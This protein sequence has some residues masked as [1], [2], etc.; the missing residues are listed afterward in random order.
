MSIFKNVCF[1]QWGRGHNHYNKAVKT[2][3][4]ESAGPM[5]DG[6]VTEAYNTYLKGIKQKAEEPVRMNTFVKRTWAEINLDHIAHNYR[7]IRQHT[8]KHA[9]VC[10]VIKA[11]GYGHGAVELAKLYER[12]GA[13]WFAVSNIE[14]AMQLRNAGIRLPVLIL[15][16]TPCDCAALLS[17]QNISQTVYSSDY[18]QALS[19]SAQQAGVKIQIHLKLDTGMSRIGLM[20]QHFARDAYSIDEAEQICRYE[21]LV[22]QGIFT[23]FSVADE[24][25]AGKSFTLQQFASF[26]HVV[27]ALEKRGIRFEIRHCANSGAFIDYKQTHLDMIRAGIILY[28]LSPSPNLKGRLDLLPAMEL[29]SVVSHVKTV[30]PGADVSYGRTFTAGQ[31]MRLA[32]V[33]VGYADGYIRAL[34]KEGRVG[35]RGCQAKI[36]GRICMDQLIADVTDIQG[37]QMGDTVTLFGTGE[38]NTPTADDIARW[39]NTINYEVT[40]LVGKRVARVYV[41]NG[42]VVH[43]VTLADKL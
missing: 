24:G 29:K 20:C 18:A 5:V 4:K 30:Q 16:Y 13:D 42:K 10:C 38:R 36:V 2:A 23:H 12:L 14:E 34:A 1:I 28:G 7:V 9:M 33:P 41:Q 40:C 27:E 37:V 11:D 3:G 43:A 6:N 31:A 32:T 39:S 17:R 21:G 8:D 25:Q 19:K 22:P 35:I 26:M 15:G